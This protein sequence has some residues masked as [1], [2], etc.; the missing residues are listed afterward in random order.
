MRGARE[1][2]SRGRPKSHAASHTAIPTPTATDQRM[3][4][5]WLMSSMTCFSF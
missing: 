5:S 3:K 1:G 4:L 2:P